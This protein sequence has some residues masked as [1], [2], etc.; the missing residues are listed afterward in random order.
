VGCLQQEGH[1]GGSKG[2]DFLSGTATVYN[3]NNGNFSPVISTSDAPSALKN[4]GTKPILVK[5]KRLNENE[6][7]F[8][9][10]G[11]DGVESFSS[12]FSSTLPVNGIDFYM[13]NQNSTNG[14]HNVYFNK[15]RIVK[16]TSSVQEIVGID[17]LKLSP[18]PVSRGADL[19][20][21]LGIGRAG[22]YDILFY[23]LSGICMGQ[24]AFQY[25]GA[26][27]LQRVQLPAFLAAGLYIVELRGSGLRERM[28]LVVE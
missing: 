2:F 11:R 27:G 20:L 23:S 21:R 13:G 7:E 10:S 9:M 19:N 28:R 17:F 5:M 18:N 8:S 1:I 3:V 15:F 22:R 4:Y 12:R 6:Y 24:T 16:L 25:T 26:P 14:K